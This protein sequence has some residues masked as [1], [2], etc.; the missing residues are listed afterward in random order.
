MTRQLIRVGELFLILLLLKGNA[1]ASN[2]LLSLK[3]AIH[4]A[5]V[6]SPTFDTAQ[7]NLTISELGYKNSIAAFLPS[8]DFSTTQGL[9]N[10]IP[11]AGNST[12]FTPNSSPL[13]S[14]VSLGITET[15]Y[16]NGTSVSNAVIASLTREYNQVALLQNRA[17]LTLGVINAF[18]DLSLNGVLLEI[19][20]EQTAMLEKQFKTASSEFQQGLKTRIDFLRF[21]TQLQRAE[22]DQNSAQNAVQTSRASLY[23]AIGAG[24]HGENDLDFKLIRINPKEDLSARLP[25]VPP[26]FE[27]IYDYQTTKIQ[28]DIN[29]RNTTFSKRN[30]WPQV[31]VTSG[32]TYSNFNYL[33][34][35]S[36]F[37]ATNQ[38]TWSAL[39]TLQYNIWDWG[40]RRRN[41]EIAEYKRDIQNNTLN[42]TLLTDS[43]QIQA[44]MANFAKV[45]KTYSISRELLSLEERNY[46]NISNQYR[47]G[48]VSY[49]DL[50]TSLT[51]FLDAKVQFYSSY[52]EALKDLA[53]Y[54]YFEGTLYE[55]F[56][57]E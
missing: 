45:S 3:D 24:L 5:V 52:F 18:Y 35:D 13:Y 26:A 10:N 37:S 51:N 54:K 17:S 16:D 56:A 4:Y 42:Q 47:Q 21:K 40:L 48:K 9:Q 22:I 55:T 34:S 41:V 44:L 30:Y 1:Q 6:H 57:V 46:Q 28:N 11:V 20:T 8:L 15:L 43:S 31:S 12:L 7:K 49:L 14:A 25:A 38:V 29:D 33:S 19:R 53:L 32:V 23:Q 2:Q 27:K 39:V 36:P 50:I